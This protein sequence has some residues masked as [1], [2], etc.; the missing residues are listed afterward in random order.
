MDIAIGIIVDVT[1]MPLT[2]LVDVL[3]QKPCAV[4]AIVIDAGRLALMDND[5]VSGKTIYFQLDDAANTLGAELYRCHIG[6]PP[7]NSSRCKSA[8]HTP[9]TV[10][11]DRSP[12]VTE[13]GFCVM[14][15]IN[16]SSKAFTE[17]HSAARSERS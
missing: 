12:N 11:P 17:A 6:S 3:H 15:V 8:F 14:F 1:A 5:E 10:R 7:Q 13:N 4:A 9:V 16:F 2:V